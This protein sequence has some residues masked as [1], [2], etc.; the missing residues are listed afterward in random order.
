MHDYSGYAD[1]RPDYVAAFEKMANLAIMSTDDK[2]QMKIH[3]PLVKLKKVEIIKIGMALN[4][5][6]SLT[7]SCYDPRDDLACGLC[8]SCFYRKKGFTDANVKDPTRYVRASLSTYP[9]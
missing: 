4:V 1:C 6:Y 5:D 2:H 7:H 9:C 8:S 3:A